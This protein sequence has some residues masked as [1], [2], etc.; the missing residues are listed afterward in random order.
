MQL[1]ERR[2]PAMTSLATTD[3]WRRLHTLADAFHSDAT[4]LSSLFAA[5]PERAARYRVELPG[6]VFDYSKHLLTAEILAGLT[7][8]AEARGLPQAIEAMF[9]GARINPTENRAAL[10][11]ALRGHAAGGHSAEVEAVLSRMDAF[12]TAV[13]AGQWRGYSGKPMTDVV[14]VGIGGSHLGPAMVVRA[15]RPFADRAVD[16]HFLA[17]VDPAVATETLGRLQPESTL[18]IIASKSFTTLETHQNAQIARRWLL[19]HGVEESDL[20][21]H[22]VAVSSNVPAARAFGIA[23]DN[24]YPMWDWVGG[25]YSLWSAIGMPIA[26][27][28]GMEGFRALLAGAQAADQHFREAPLTGNIPALMGLLTVW[29]SGFHGGTSQAILPYRQSLEL[30][31][32]FLQQLC[33]ESLGKGVDLNGGPMGVDTGTVVWGAVGTDGQHSFHQLLH[34][35]TRMVPADFIAVAEPTYPGGDEPHRHLLANCFSQSQALMAGKSLEQA[36]QE[37]LAAGRTAAE[38]AA[39]APHKVIPGNRPSS[40]FL[41]HRLDPATLGLLTAF[42]EHSVYV[43]SVIWGINAF[44]QWGVELGKQLSGPLYAALTTGGTAD[45][46]DASTRYLVDMARTWQTG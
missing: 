14:N 35:G 36:T 40:T 20:A 7:G 39:L 1:S 33:M 30:F 27:A 4:T 28:V 24:I 9:S 11:V 22:F 15:L 45:S 3:A 12:V 5:D 19:D 37:L 43:Q 29:Y 32:A 25:R 2:A 44:D 23:E 46:L 41:L 8:L 26:M 42:Y 31:P 18:F 16:C 6:L 34:Q 38:A 10:H 21:R 13:R 17:N